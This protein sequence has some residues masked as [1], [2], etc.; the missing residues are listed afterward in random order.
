MKEGESYLQCGLFLGFSWLIA[1]SCLCWGLCSGEGG[2]LLA[3][4]FV[5]GFSYQWSQGPYI[6][7]HS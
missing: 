3:Y 7:T 2:T 1:H 5:A 6:F 4:V